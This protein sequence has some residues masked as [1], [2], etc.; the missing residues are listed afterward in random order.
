MM[1]KIIFLF[2]AILMLFGCNNATKTTSQRSNI[3]ILAESATSIQSMMAFEQDYES[4][5]PKINLEFKP[6][7]FDDAFNKANQ[8][9]ANKTGLYDI[10]MQYNFSLSSFVRN[11]YVYPLDE[12]LVKIPD[13]L[14]HFEKDLFQNAWKE[15]GFYANSTKTTEPIKVGYPFAANTMFL[16]Y[17]KTLFE[18]PK[19]IAAYQ[20]KY[21][22]VL[23]IPTSWEQF[24]KVAA[25]FTQPEN[26]LHGVCLQGATGGWLY[27]EWMNFLFSM[28]GKVM[29]KQYGWQGDQNTKVLLNTPEALKALNFYKSFKPFNKGNFTNVDAYE[30]IKIFKEGKTAMAIIWSDLAYNMVNMPNDA[31]DN[32]FGFVTIPGNKSLLAGGSYFINRQ[33]KNPDLALQYIIDLMQPQSQVAL[34]KKGLCSALKTVYTHPD[35]QKLPYCNA[36]KNSLDRGV[37][38]LEAGIDATMISEKITTYLQ[39]AWND[40]LTSEKALEK[41]QSEIESERNKIFEALKK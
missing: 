11:N 7:S 26:Q 35:V 15:I 31:I 36:M 29:D 13:S 4:K 18:D 32:R 8:D 22:E 16:T 38:M 1:K 20:Q 21:H 39:K 6:N 25:F 17:N 3:T 12:L 28:G 37:Y 23:T 5:H 2:S 9:F 33:S 30:Q 19:H 34:T 40:E 41:M 10:V 27:Y 14:R 24:Y